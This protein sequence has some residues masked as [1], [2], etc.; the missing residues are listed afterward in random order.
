MSRLGTHAGKGLEVE[1]VALVRCGS[2]REMM[3]LEARLIRRYNPPLNLRVAGERCET[4]DEREGRV[5]YSL[6]ITPEAKQQ[7]VERADRRGVSTAEM[8]RQLLRLGLQHAHTSDARMRQSILSGQR[9]AAPVTDP[10]DD[11]PR[12]AI[13]KALTMAEA[14]RLKLEKARRGGYAKP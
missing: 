10:D 5:M 6:Y 3:A 14:K 4:A 13:G 9:S 2:R 11:D 1:R 7:V 12:A 8:F